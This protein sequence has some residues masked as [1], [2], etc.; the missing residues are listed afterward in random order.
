MTKKKT[1]ADY[2]S[3]GDEEAVVVDI[4]THVEEEA[5][6][7]AKDPQFVD[8]AESQKVWEKLNQ[9]EDEEE[10]EKIAAQQADPMAEDEVFVRGIDLAASLGLS[11]LAGNWDTEKYGI[12]EPKVKALIIASNKA[13]LGKK[14]ASKLGAE[15]LFW[16]M[17]AAS[18][19]PAAK[20]AVADR[21]NLRKKKITQTVTKGQ[22]FKP[23]K[24]NESTSTGE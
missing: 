9:K 6:E 2:F 13:G 1:E 24:V 11:I 15:T 17:V 10:A 20:A 7:L 4:N 14:Y 23:E 3:N 16:S 22:K 21:M 18:Y 12:P 19:A 5:A 8:D